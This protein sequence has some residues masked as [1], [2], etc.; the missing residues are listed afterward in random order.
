MR[1][2]KSS[3]VAEAP[4]QKHIAFWGDLAGG[5]VAQP[6]L[7]KFYTKEQLL[8]HLQSRLRNLDGIY[9]RTT[10][11]YRIESARVTREA[12]T[13]LINKIRKIEDFA[14][15]EAQ[16]ID[17]SGTLA[18][19]CQKHRIPTPDIVAR[20]REPEKAEIPEGMDFL[21]DE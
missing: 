18:A 7:R 9:E 4:E 2:E 8:T 16:P 20:K 10:A 6:S 12:L 11:P 13:K 17:V 19:Y 15:C 3:D 5:V 14:A 21:E 1:K